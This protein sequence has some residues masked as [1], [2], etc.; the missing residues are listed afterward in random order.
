MWTTISQGRAWHGEIKNRAKDGSF[1]WVDTTI[2]PFVNQDGTPRQYVAIRAD[3]TDRKR[4]EEALQGSEERF[5]AMANAMSQLGWIA[6]PDGHIFWYNQRWYEYTGTTPEQMEGWGW[7]DVQDK[8]E[9][10]KVLERWQASIATGHPFEMMFPLRGA[11]GHFRQFLTR[12]VPLKDASGCVVQWFGTN[13]DVEELTLA[14]KALS[15]STEQLRWTEESFRLMVESVSDC[16]IIMLDPDGRIVSWNNG[17]QR[18]KGYSAR[19]IIGQHFSQFHLRE[20]I[21]CGNPQSELE[22]AKTKGRFETNGWRVRKDGKTFWANVVFTAVRDQTGNLRGFA[23]LTRDL[24]EARS[25]DQL[26][27]DNNMELEKA[28][29]VA[30]DANRAKSDFLSSMSHELRTPLNGILGFAQL[31]ETGTPPPTPNQKRSLDQI[32]KGGWYLLELINEILDLAL[33]ESGKVSLSLEPVSLVEVMKDCQ[34]LIE[35]LA[36]KRDISTR[37]QHLELPYFVNVDRTR[38]KQVLLN[39]LSNAIKYNTLG[40]VVT[41]E[42]ALNPSNFVRISVR[43]TGMGMIPEQ[44]SQ[45]FQPFNR[46]GKEASAETGTGIGLVV[47]KRLVELMNGI[48]GA[49][50]T[51]GAGSVFWIELPLATKLQHVPVEA[52]HPAQIRPHG[53]VDML[54][55]TLLYVEDNPSNVELIEQ[56]VARRPGVRMISAADGNLGIEYARAFLPNVILMDINLPGISGLDAMKIL[57][58][59]PMTVNIPIIAISANAMPTDIEH[60]LAAGCFKYLTKPIKINEFM[61]VLDLA[62]SITNK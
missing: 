44:L 18:I 35:P 7:Q 40:G 12:V 57:R 39:L 48:V 28:R 55:R 2:V 37:F 41:V 51:V 45:L 10:P 3:I 24:T 58:A 13:T 14:Q 53:L 19:E 62:L 15:E 36:Q 54:Q 42:C 61:A 50:S 23:K 27:R 11:D 21:D 38:F 8:V 43:D 22:V 31:I 17:A 26:L 29:F 56:L 4:A 46:L 30:D 60:A 16:A 59:D 33:I 34:T 32:L 49:E 1:Y 6:R 5:R 47:T 25:R 9:L 20:E 52:E